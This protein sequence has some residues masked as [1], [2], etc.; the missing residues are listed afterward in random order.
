MSIAVNKQE[1]KTLITRLKA[2]AKKRNIPF[3]LSASDLDELGLPLTCPVLHIPLKFHRGAPQDDSYSIDRI[4]S[5]KGYTAD[6]I[7]IISN[8]ANIL[9]RDAT[10]TELKQ[11]VEYYDNIDR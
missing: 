8:R 11:L 6:N 2:S 5:S 1:L 4:D 9:K 7:T 10:L 3:D